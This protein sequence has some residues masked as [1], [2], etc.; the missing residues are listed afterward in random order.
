MR[1]PRFDGSMRFSC[2]APGGHRY[3][4]SRA[5]PT[6]P[7]W[8]NAARSEGPHTPVKV[9]SGRDRSS[10]RC[11]PS[12]RSAPTPKP[13]GPPDQNPSE[14]QP[15]AANHPRTAGV[16]SEGRRCRVQ[17]T[18]APGAAS[19]RSASRSARRPR[20]SR[21]R[22]CRTAGAGRRVRHRPR[23]TGIPGV[24]RADLE[25]GPQWGEVSPRA[26]A[27]SSASSSTRQPVRSAARGWAVAAVTTS[28]P[29]PAH[30]DNSSTGP[31]PPGRARP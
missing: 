27:A 5:G 2:A 8:C 25:L 31:G 19:P 17:I 18:V 6:R 23:P 12:N 26:A 14:V 4:W 9:N 20:P 3:L 1:S 10:G 16:R 7:L 11:G 22:R 28:R 30:N 13:P 24:G 15:A 29:S 21:S